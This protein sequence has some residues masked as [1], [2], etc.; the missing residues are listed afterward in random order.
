MTSRSQ[1]LEEILKKW[2]HV[3]SIWAC[4]WRHGRVHGQAFSVFFMLRRSGKFDVGEEIPAAA[5]E[6]HDKDVPLGPLCTTS[7]KYHHYTCRDPWV[8]A[9]AGF[10]CCGTT[11]AD[12]YLCMRA[13]E[14]AFIIM[15]NENKIKKYVF[16]L[17][18]G[19]T[20]SQVTVH[21]SLFL[22]ITI[23]WFSI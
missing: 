12:W 14:Q 17:I 6:C 5:T 16:I 19:Q 4:K 10:T 3:T 21:Q 23:R 7:A 2:A 9:E 8:R 13:R 22:K 1:S 15:L 18:S 11:F 20:N